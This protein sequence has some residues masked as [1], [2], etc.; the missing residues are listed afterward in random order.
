MAMA[1]LSLHARI[2]AELAALGRARSHVRG[3]GAALDRSGSRGRSLEDDDEKE[4]AVEGGLHHLYYDRVKGWVLRVTVG[5]GKNVI[6]KRLKFYLRT[7]DLAE[8]EKA[9]AWVLT[10][11]RKLGLTVKGCVQSKEGEGTRGR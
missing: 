1:K 10:T 8:A 4:C 7:R 5:L 9:R 6:G 11:L 3:R 2:M